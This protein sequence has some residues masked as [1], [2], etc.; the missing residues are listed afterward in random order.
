M[1]ISIDRLQKVLEKAGSATYAEARFHSRIRNE[2]TVGNGEVEEAKSTRIDG[3]GLRVLVDGAWGFSS[4]NDTSTTA[5]LDALKDALDIARVSATAKKKKTTRLA[6]TELARGVFRPP[7][8][9]PLEHHSLEEKMKLVTETEAA[10]RRH[11]DSV[12]TASCRYR[13]MIDHKIIVSTDGAAAEVFLSKP[14][15]RVMAVASRN[16]DR[17]SAAE[18]VGVTGGWKDLFEKWS[19]EEM[20]RKAAETAKNLLDARH[21]K[22]ER[23]KVILDPGMVGLIAHEAVGHTVEADFVLSGSIVRG[24]LGEEVAS[25]LVTLVDSG[26]SDIVGGAAGVVLVDDEGV[27]A[28][29]TVVIKE[30]VLESYL[31]SR[32]TAAEFG[33]KPTGNA[34]AYEY[35][36]EPLIRMRNTYIEPGDYELEEMIREVDHGYLLKGPRSG[37]ADAN[38]EFM[39]GAQRAYLIEKGEVKDLLKGATISG[40]ALDVLQTV[41]ALGKDFAYDLGSGYCGK[42]QPAKVDGGGPYLRCEALIGGLQ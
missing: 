31:H 28:G 27:T 20:S 2:I 9:D 38:G 15:F 12:K 16:G 39:F 14:E 6:E 10:T 40:M 11:F 32:E 22:G 25:S 37:Q 19:A 23:A 30:G 13:E 41:D 33:V 7:I 42:R 21:P 24:K 3:V 36:D 17:M 5:L 1:Q 29:K 8:N 26:R 34:R 35:S 4:T 18:T